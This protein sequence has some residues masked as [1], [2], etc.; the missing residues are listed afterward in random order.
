MSLMNSISII[1]NIL[2]FICRSH[3][4]NVNSI[5]LIYAENIRLSRKIL[6]NIHIIIQFWADSFQTTVDGRVVFKNVSF[7]YPMRPEVRVLKSLSFTVEPGQTVALVGPS[8]C[9]KS[10]AISLLQRMYDV[11]DGEIVRFMLKQPLQK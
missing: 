6:L 10:T 2:V 7:S 5:P 1:E 11:E 3:A 9:G 8:G 4:L